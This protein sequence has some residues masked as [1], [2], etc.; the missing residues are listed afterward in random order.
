MQTIESIEAGAHFS[1]LMQRVVAGEEFLVTLDGEPVV[2][3]TRAEPVPKTKD[4]DKTLSELAA[5]RA[6]RA[7]L[8]S[9]L[10]PGET[11]NDLAREGR[12]W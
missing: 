5:F 12:K 11:W 9:V 3:M 6:E 8:G 4:R 10:K 1:D 2:R 7:K